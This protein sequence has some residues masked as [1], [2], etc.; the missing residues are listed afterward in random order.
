M[1]KHLVAFLAPD[2][3]V[4]HRNKSS[5]TIFTNC[6]SLLLTPVFREH[7]KVQPLM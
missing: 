7:E 3:T 2:V 4:S 6:N 1:D 5:C